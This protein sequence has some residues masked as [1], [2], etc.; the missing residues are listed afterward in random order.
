MLEQYNMGVSAYLGAL[1]A[2]IDRLP[3]GDIGAVVQALRQAYEEDRAIFV[4][5]NGGSAATASHMVV[6]LNKGA[7]LNAGK[8]FRVLCLNDSIPSVT[9]IGNDLGYERVFV[10]PLKNFARP[11]DVV[12]AISGSGNSPN[13]L[14]AIEYA[15][16]TGCV[17]IGLC[18]FDG[19]R[20]HQLVRHSI[21]AAVHDMQLVEDLHM[22]MVHIF[23]RLLEVKD[24][25]MSP[26]ANAGAAVLAG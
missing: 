14:R 10:E 2:E 20:L 16:E 22:V 25:P 24:A 23:L 15:N 12:I 4:M 6:D 9:A 21:L 7:C 18:G 13:V 11:G 1:K 26:G 19:G 5:G 3:V 8:K 17:T